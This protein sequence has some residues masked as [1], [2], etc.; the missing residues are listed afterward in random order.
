ML[1]GN[2]FRIKVNGIQDIVDLFQSSPTTAITNCPH[3][4]LWDKK[5]ILHSR[6]FYKKRYQ[7]F[8]RIW[9]TIDPNLWFFC[10]A[11][12][13]KLVFYCLDTAVWVCR[14]LRLLSLWWTNSSMLFSYSIFLITV[15][16]KS[17]LN[18]IPPF[19]QSPRGKKKKG[20]GPLTV[21]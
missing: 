14:S 8:T 4:M 9:K 10:K 17:Y 18:D 5:E 20:G 6:S 16:Q 19:G 11:F 7:S 2:A 15:M 3:H 13:S 1:F 21:Q 12:N